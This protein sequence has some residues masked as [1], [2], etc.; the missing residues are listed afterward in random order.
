MTDMN[1][2]N[3]KNNNP[4]NEIDNL[5]RQREFGDRFR[6]AREAAGLS[7]AEVAEELRLAEDIIKALENSQLDSLPAPTF[8]QGYIRSYAKMLKLPVDEIIKAYDRLI[9]EKEAPLTGRSAVSVQKDSSDIAIKLISFGLLIAALVLL[10]FWFQQ[11]DFKFLNSDNINDY[12]NEIGSEGSQTEITEFPAETDLRPYQATTETVVEQQPVP[13]PDLTS[14]ITDQ[15]ISDNQE[16]IKKEIINS[17]ITPAVSTVEESSPKEDSNMD[18]AI[19]QPITEKNIISNQKMIQDA[20]KKNVQISQPVTGDDV[21]VMATD[22]E[23]WAEVE[24]ANGVR[25]YFDLMK[26][27]NEYKLRGQAPFKLFLGNA[28]TVTIGVN[29]KLLNV[30]DYIRRNNIAHIQITDKG[31]ISPMRGRIAVPEAYL[32]KNINQY[33]EAENTAIKLE[34]SV[35]DE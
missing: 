1:N 26:K 5:I 29:N 6:A 16:P 7:T 22:D 17:V 33:P 3:N 24:D 9:P 23:S 11:T 15:N 18:V 31:D 21:L 20:A 13:V 28:P 14:E 10:A 19:A 30:S 4:G 32:D 2:Q 8:T 34:P 27:D 35:E 12:V 25:L